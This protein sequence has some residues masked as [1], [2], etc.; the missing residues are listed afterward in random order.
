LGE[1]P[2]Q[3][4]LNLSFL[5]SWKWRKGFKGQHTW[6]WFRMFDSDC[7][8]HVHTSLWISHFC[9]I[10]LNKE[11]LPPQ[12]S[13]QGSVTMFNASRD[14]WAAD[15]IDTDSLERSIPCSE[16]SIVIIIMAI[17][18]VLVLLAILW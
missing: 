2:L 6:T 14:H 7:S 15:F 8:C 10:N 13:Q 17:P 12:E 9:V 1:L 11:Y 16:D 3:F 18:R 4:C 5:R